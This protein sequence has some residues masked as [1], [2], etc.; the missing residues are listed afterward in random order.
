MPVCFGFP[1]K[2]SC[3]FFDCCYGEVASRVHVQ[4]MYQTLKPNQNTSHKCLTNI[5]L[6]K[7]DDIYSSKNQT[8]LTKRIHVFLKKFFYGLFLD[9]C[10]LEIILTNRAARASDSVV[11]NQEEK[12]QAFETSTRLERLS[13]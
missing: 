11:C 1:V 2:S 10:I 4:N 3:F 5:G 7:K 9:N 12:T 8:G 13:T 6:N